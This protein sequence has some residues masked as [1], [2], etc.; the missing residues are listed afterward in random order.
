MPLP[1]SVICRSLMPPSL[2]TMVIWVAPEGHRRRAHP[3]QGSIPYK[4]HVYRCMQ[5]C[6]SVQD[7]KRQEIFAMVSLKL[8]VESK[9]RKKNPRPSVRIKAY[10][11]ASRLFSSISFSAEAGLW[12]TSPAAMRLTTSAES[13]WIG[14]GASGDSGCSWLISDMYNGYSIGE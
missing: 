7:L 4:F 1:L 2:T 13:R 6:L 5:V 9:M 3:D 8:E 14:F 12:M 11:P 10:S